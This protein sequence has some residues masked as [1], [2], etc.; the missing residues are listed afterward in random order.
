[1]AATSGGAQCNFCWCPS[2][3]GH[4]NGCPEVGG[5]KAKAEWEAGYLYGW[6]DNHLQGHEY[7]YCS[8][9]FILGWHVGSDEIDAAVDAAVEGRMYNY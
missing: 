7:R 2:N 1:M 5:P 3:L 6:E 4:N 9:S 8:P